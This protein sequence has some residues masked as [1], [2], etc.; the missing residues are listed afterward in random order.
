MSDHDTAFPPYT[1]VPGLGRPHPVSSPLGHSHGVVHPPAEPIRGGDW[2]ESR[3]FKLG[4]ALFNAG[5]YWEAHEA[6]ERLWH[7]H[8]REGAIADLLKALIKLAAAGVKVRQGQP[9]GVVV[10]AR[11]AADLFQAIQNQTQEQML[12]GLNL[13]RFAELA[14][15]IAD[16]PPL[17]PVG[18]NAVVGPVFSFRI[19]PEPITPS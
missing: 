13:A 11:R 9:A 3:D 15:S 5:Y 19:D 4:A 17:D 6:W 18:R 16:E 12:L 1:Y 10:H 2:S 7:A 14:R 8:G